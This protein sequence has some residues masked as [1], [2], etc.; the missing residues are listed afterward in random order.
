MAKAIIPP[1]ANLPRQTARCCTA[2]AVVDQGSRAGLAG[3]ATSAAPP[4]ARN[5]RS[6]TRVRGIDDGNSSKRATPDEGVDAVHAL[7]TQAI[8]SSKFAKCQWR[9]FRSPII[10]STRAPALLG[11]ATSR[12]HAGRDQRTRYSR[13]GEQSGR[14]G[15]RAE[16]ASGPG[17]DLARRYKMT[18][19]AVCGMAGNDLEQ[20]RG[21]MAGGGT[22]ARR[23]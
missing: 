18:G 21:L 19:G 9:R 6:A 20:R 7:S 17:A 13:T 4:P 1:V 5:R 15:E 8:L 11:S 3:W 23:G 2:G 22:L 14:C 12:I 10:G 16:F